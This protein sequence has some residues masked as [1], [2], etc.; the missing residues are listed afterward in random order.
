[1]KLVVLLGEQ[2]LL[3]NLKKLV[4]LKFISLKVG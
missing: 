1:M 4:F 3:K 2:K